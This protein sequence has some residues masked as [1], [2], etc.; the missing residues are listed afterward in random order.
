MPS[1]LSPAVWTSVCTNNVATIEDQLR[2]AQ[3]C[4]ALV[5]LQNYLHTRTHFIKHRNSNIRGQRANT[6]ANTLIDSLSSKIH[7]AVKKYRAA[8][9]ALHGLRGAGPW[10]QELHVLQSTDICGP[11]ASI[12]GDINDANDIISS[13]GH[14]KSKRQCE[15][16]SRGLGEGYR[17]T[18]WIW[19]CRTIASGEMGITDG[20][21]SLL[22]GI[23]LTADFKHYA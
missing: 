19:A 6:R 9:S 1:R 7:R 23:V 3:C 20:K 14:R 15:A 5:K 8:R 22:K 17:T 11:T 16:L 21:P 12:S 4:D 18:S 10:E 2:E 13:D